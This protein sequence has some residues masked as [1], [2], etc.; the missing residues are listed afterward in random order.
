MTVP[1]SDQD[2]G[3]VGTARTEATSLAHAATDSAQ[4]VT[5]T[6]KTQASQVA[7]ETAHQARDLLQ[8]AKSA[9]SE[10]GATQQQ[11]VAANLRTLSEELRSMTDHQGS[12]GVA[13]NLAGEGASRIEAA[14][15]W[16][17]QREPGSLIDE[18][19]EFGRRRPLMFL[20]AAAAAGLVAGRLTRAVIAGPAQDSE[21]AD[22]ARG[23][24]YAPEGVPAAPYDPALGRP[25]ATSDFMPAD[26]SQVG[27]GAVAAEYPLT[28]DEPPGEGISG[29]RTVGGP[30][31][32]L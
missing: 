14:A 31:N 28:A 5:Q 29:A 23:E 27:L 9:V 15:H 25:Y 12:S 2:Q 32:P 18:L 4:Q 10:Q 11:R 19:A 22:D 7:S 3:A 24:Q 13:T 1:T 30:E 16:L 26:Q 20:A 8:Q 17:E 6:A 21:Q